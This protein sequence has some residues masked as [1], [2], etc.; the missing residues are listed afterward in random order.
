MSATIDKTRPTAG[1]H[2][3]KKQPFM[4]EF[5][6]GARQALHSSSH[7]LIDLDVPEHFHCPPPHFNCRPHLEVYAAYRFRSR[8]ALFSR[9]LRPPSRR[10]VAVWT[11]YCRVDY[12]RQ[13]NHRD[14]H[15]DSRH[16]T[17]ELCA[18]RHFNGGL[19]LP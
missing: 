10:F 19:Y 13:I 12:G 2:A 6:V 17:F 7:H 3:F 1:I 15:R 9:S 5:V 18:R 16:S 14:G 8:I 4:S 11:C